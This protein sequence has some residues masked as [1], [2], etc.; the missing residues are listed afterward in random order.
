MALSWDSVETFFSF[1]SRNRHFMNK[2]GKVVAELR[3]KK[4]LWDL[5]LLCGIS[6]HANDLNTKPQV[7]QKLISDV[8]AFEMKLKLFRK[9]LENVNMCHFSS[10]VLLHNDG[11]VCCSLS[12]CP[13][14]RNIWWFG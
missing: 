1:E 8:R 2:K 9:Q 12:K 3:D 7:Q 13:C 6:R 14:Y 11:S 5:A 4:F 10:C